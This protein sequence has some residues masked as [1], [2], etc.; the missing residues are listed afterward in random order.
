MESA[1]ISLPFGAQQIRDS[2]KKNLR[3]RNSGTICSFS[4][5]VEQIFLRH[6]MEQVYIE[7][8]FLKQWFDFS[9]VMWQ[10]TLKKK[11]KKQMMWKRL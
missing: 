6:I 2:L 3:E 4:S 7:R 9:L 5:A 1:I 8:N 10:P 11:P